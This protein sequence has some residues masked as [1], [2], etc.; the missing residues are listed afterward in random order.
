[1]SRTIDLEGIVTDDFGYKV[2][3]SGPSK[4]QGLL[5][6]KGRRVRKISRSDKHG[7][8]HTLEAEQRNSLHG[9]VMEKT[10]EVTE[11]FQDRNIMQ[12]YQHR[13]AVMQHI[14]HDD[15]EDSIARAATGI[16]DW[17]LLDTPEVVTALPE[18]GRIPKSFEVE[19]H[20]PS[21]SE[22]FPEMPASLLS[23]VLMRE[24]TSR[25]FSSL[26][27]FASSKR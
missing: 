27:P 11:V 25:G 23:P 17:S 19:S 10:F 4:P 1:M 16:L 3:I 12:K 7:I 15:V 22:R 24:R 26:T 13:D 14:S 18:M 21:I 5:R 9:V 6:N 20:Q 8:D 2:T